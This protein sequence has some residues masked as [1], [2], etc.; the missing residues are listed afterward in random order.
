MEGGVGT[1]GEYQEK[2]QCT[3]VSEHS[4]LSRARCHLQGLQEG[5]AEQAMGR[6]FSQVMTALLL[7]A[8]DKVTW[9]EAWPP[10]VPNKRLN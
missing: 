8:V 2:A 10:N 4:H 3:L 5:K 6:L 1:K 9:S 7:L